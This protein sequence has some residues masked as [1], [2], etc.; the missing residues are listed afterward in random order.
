MSVYSQQPQ[1]NAAVFPWSLIDI[2]YL[3]RSLLSVF[4][5]I[6]FPSYRVPLNLATGSSGSEL[7]ATSERD[8][9]EESSN[10]SCLDD[11]GGRFACKEAATKEVT[12]NPKDEEPPPQQVTVTAIPEGWRYFLQSGT[13]SFVGI[14]LLAFFL[15]LSIWNTWRAITYVYSPLEEGMIGLRCT[16]N[17]SFC[18]FA[19]VLIVAGTRWCGSWGR[20]MKVLGNVIGGIGLW[21]LIE[22]LVSYSTDQNHAYDLV[23]YACALTICSL[24]VFILY[25]WRNINIIDSSLLSPV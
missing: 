1:R 22:S 6:F 2:G 5:L 24:V 4:S 20:G 9:V 21:E 13:V 8:I 17:I 7:T 12:L 14:S 15:T 16:L 23:I 25:R 3:G 11:H 18:L 10:V 19:V